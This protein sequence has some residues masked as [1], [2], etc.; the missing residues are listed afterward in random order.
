M[1]LLCPRGEQ[2]TIAGKGK[3]SASGHHVGG[4][5]TDG[6]EK[7][8]GVRA[9][10]C[11]SHWRGLSIKASINM[12]QKTFAGATA[13]IPPPFVGNCFCFI[14][15][16]YDLM[17]PEPV[18]IAGVVTLG[19]PHTH[20]LCLCESRHHLQFY[21]RMKSSESGWD[22]YMCIFPLCIPSKVSGGGSGCVCVLLVL[23][24]CFEEEKHLSI[25]MPPWPSVVKHAPTGLELCWSPHFM[26]SQ[27]LTDLLTAITNHKSS[28]TEG[29]YLLFWDLDPLPLRAKV[30]WQHI[31]LSAWRPLL[32]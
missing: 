3:F 9:G 11:M 17:K 30:Q 1:S 20:F 4:N 29:S 13:C 19:S 32:W 7:P 24:E 8:R 21:R 23:S 16:F 31:R 18:K 6:E 27:H 12:G 15:V 28:P 5:D 25:L 10:C 22:A 14:W 2:Q 26:L